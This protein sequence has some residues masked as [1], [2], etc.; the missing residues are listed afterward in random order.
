MTQERAYDPCVSQKQADMMQHASHDV[1]Y[2]ATRNV[3][4]DVAQGKHAATIAAGKHGKY[5]GGPC[6]KC[7]PDC[8]HEA[9][10]LD[11]YCADCGA[12]ADEPAPE[13]APVADSGD[14]IPDLF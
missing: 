1:E 8:A 10:T 4:Q 2:A 9:G 3:P 13:S 12:L 6:P 5:D 11:G 7:H 14:G